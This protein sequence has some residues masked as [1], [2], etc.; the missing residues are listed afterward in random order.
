MLVPGHFRETLQSHRAIIAALA[1][2]NPAKAEE[3]AKE[4]HQKT[5][6]YLLTILHPDATRAQEE[7]RSVAAQGAAPHNGRKGNGASHS[8]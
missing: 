2:R 7:E 3:A 6:Q 5:I 4:H 8:I 1:T